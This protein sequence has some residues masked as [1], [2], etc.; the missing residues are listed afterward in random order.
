MFF[1][2]APSSASSSPS[3][4]PSQNKTTSPSIRT[5]PLHPASLVPPSQHAPALLQLADVNI[6]DRVVDYVVHCVASTVDFAM[7]RPPSSFSSASPPT[8][9]RSSQSRRLKIFTTFTATLLTRAE[10]TPSTLAVALLYIR[11]VRRVLS[12]AVE[13]WALHRIFL[14]AVMAASKYTN[15]STL[16]NVHWALCTGVFGQRDV[17]R[18]ERE[19]L[20]VIGWELRVRERG[21]MRVVEELRMSRSVTR[22]HR[23]THRRHPPSSPSS[24]ASSV[25]ELDPSSPRSSLGSVSPRTPHSTPSRTPYSKS[26]SPSYHPETAGTA[27]YHRKEGGVGSKLHDLLRLFSGLPSSRHPD[28]LRVGASP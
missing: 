11:R 27:G 14:G 20:A 6:S 23:R 18:I 26:S 4:S 22:P 25:P 1:D 2:D 3:P 28:E 12:I 24:G 15:D 5:G 17:G 19:F 13:E 8:R 16:K 10:V 21:L 9:G 7:G